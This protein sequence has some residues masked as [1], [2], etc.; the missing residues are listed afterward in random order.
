MTHPEAL[1]VLLDLPRWTDAGAAAYKP[2]LDRMRALLAAM[3]SP[4]LQYP[5]LH[6][7]G[8]NGKGSTASFTAAVLTA[9]GRRV[10]LHTSPH[11]VALEERMRVDG[12]PASPHWLAD[13]VGRFEGAFREVGPSFFEATTALAFLHFAEQRVDV[14]VVEVGLGGRLDATN[15]L[16]PLA[17]AVTNV[18]LDHTDILGTTVAAIAREKAGI[19]KPGVPFLT[20]AT[21]EAAEVLEAEAV[22]RGA[23]FFLVGWGD[24]E[25]EG[26]DLAGDPL[27]GGQQHAG[28][29]PPTPFRDAGLRLFGGLRT[30]SVQE[31]GWE[32]ATS[33]GASSPTPPVPP[34]PHPYSN[35]HTSTRPD[36]H[37]QLGLPGEHQRLNALLAV[38]LAR[39]AAPDLTDEAIATGLQDVARLSGLRGRGEGWPGDPRVTLD[40]AHNADGWRVAVAAAR[41]EAGGR[42][43]ALVGVM[44]DKDA[45]RLA[46]TLAAADAVAL[47]VGLPGERALSRD[48]LVHALKNRGVPVVNGP[49]GTDAAAALAWFRAHGTN[50]DRLLVTGSH[51][52]VSEA[53]HVLSREGNPEGTGQA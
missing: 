6:V 43:Y 42:L 33:T 34:S 19:A 32:A 49:G 52:T 36:V 13:A 28:L 11:L 16:T 50:R 31:G 30:G 51:V 12:V 46:A 29:P 2:G 5:A 26:V 22:R 21:G 27:P 3:G 7:G 35:V 4:H 15:V 9:S 1:A 20:T 23:R 14:A 24:A 44:A 45:D 8:T 38:R 40:V 18:G 41:P 39:Y 53:L 10:G 37:T 25:G 47:P 17:G 48:G